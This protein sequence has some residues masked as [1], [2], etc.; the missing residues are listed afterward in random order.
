MKMSPDIK[1]KIPNVKPKQK[2]IRI[3]RCQCNKENPYTTLNLAGLEATLYN[4]S[5]SAF[6]VWCWF[7]MNKEGYEF[8]LTGTKVQKD[9]HISKATY[10]KAIKELIDYGYLRQALLFPNFQGY[11]FVEGGEMSSEYQEEKELVNFQGRPQDS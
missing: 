10:D 9:C 3:K 6:K 5:P 2:A 7:C 8:A 11:I 1:Y 4:L